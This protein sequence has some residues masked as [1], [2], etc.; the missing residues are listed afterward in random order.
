VRKIDSIVAHAGSPLV[1]YR[2]VHAIIPSR[3]SK[4]FTNHGEEGA[5]GGGRG[6]K[7]REVRVH[8]FIQDPGSADSS[9][10][11]H[12]LIPRILSTARS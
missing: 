8:N 12:P 7:R 11:F 3:D 10:R 5:G 6:K 4:R 9:F 1:V 2:E